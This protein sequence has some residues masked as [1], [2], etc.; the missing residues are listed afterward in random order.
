MPKKRV[1]NPRPAGAS[2][3]PSRSPHIAAIMAGIV[4]GDS[5][6]RTAE[7]VNP[8]GEGHSANRA[9]AAVWIR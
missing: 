3:G 9:K 5:P 4:H 7:I 6:N 8:T 1:I 2:L